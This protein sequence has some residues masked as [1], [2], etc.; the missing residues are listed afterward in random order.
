MV[1][2]CLAWWFAIGMVL[3]ADV[4]HRPGTARS[5]TVVCYALCTM[6]LSWYVLIPIAVL[7]L[8]AEPRFAY[9]VSAALA[10]ALH[11]G[12]ALYVN[13]RV[14]VRFPLPDGEIKEIL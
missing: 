7:L 6:P 8:H 14:L 1:G 4:R 12:A 3:I 5:W 10:L 13:L 2:Y 9:P 11:V